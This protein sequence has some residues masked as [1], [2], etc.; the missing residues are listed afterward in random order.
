MRLRTHFD[1]MY[2][3]AY[4]WCG[5]QADAEDIAQSFCVKLVR[6]LKTYGFQSSFLTWLYSLVI[7]TAKDLVRSRARQPI[8]DGTEIDHPTDPVTEERVYSNQVIAQIQ[9]L[10]NKEK[11]ALFLV[12]GDGLTHREA[13]AV[14]ECKESTVSWY[15]HEARKKLQAFR[16][17]ES[18]HG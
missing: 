6:S 5:N 7:N 8:A 1:V 17:L 2:R 3:I 11:E 14:M 15:I 13:A 12:F 10:P 18:S 16:R 9:T 4:K